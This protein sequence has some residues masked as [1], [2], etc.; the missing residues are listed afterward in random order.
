M[1]LDEF[2]RQC[3]ITGQTKWLQC[4]LLALESMKWSMTVT[5]PQPWKKV[6]ITYDWKEKE[7]PCDL[8]GLFS[9]YQPMEASNT[10]KAKSDH[11]YLPCA[12]RFWIQIQYFIMFA[13][14]HR[15]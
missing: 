4:S 5:G 15:I 9:Q 10:H 14:L 6:K 3:H 8:I 11:I 7:T 2:L 12:F 13:L 1:L